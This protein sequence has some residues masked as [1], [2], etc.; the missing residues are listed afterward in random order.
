MAAS[1]VR[2]TPHRVVRS[3]AVLLGG[4]AG[5]VL[6]SVILTALARPAGATS[7]PLGSSQASVP[8]VAV[9]GVSV[10]AGSTRMQPVPIIA[11]VTQVMTTKATD[12]PSSAVNSQANGP[13]MVSRTAGSLAAQALAAR[14]AAAN[15]IGGGLGVPMIPLLGGVPMSVSVVS[16]AAPM[17]VAALQSLETAHA[18]IANTSVNGLTAV[19]R[20]AWGNRPALPAPLAPD[21]AP[22]SPYPSP[23][24][25][26]AANDLSG[27]SSSGQGGSPFGSGPPSSVLLPVLA[28]GGVLLARE[29]RPRLLLDSRCSPPG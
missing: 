23:N 19:P 14:N 5:V 6:G 29:T 9:P 10:P 20:S 27:D 11:S 7:L 22:T 3:L 4:I 13:A 16:G 12:V 26:L 17:A 15:S 18:G 25:V 28:L 24:S 2:T 8:P 21:R 1:R